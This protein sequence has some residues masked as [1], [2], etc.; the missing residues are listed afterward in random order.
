MKISIWLLLLLLLIQATV[1]AVLHWPGGGDS[2]LAATGALLPFDPARID[3]V[4]IGDEYDNEVVLLQVDKAHWALPEMDDLPANANA[5]RQLVTALDSS[6]HQVPIATT[7]AA[8]QRFQVASYR[9]QRQIRLVGNGEILAT[10]YLGTAPGFRQV[11]ARNEERDAIYNIA[12]NNHDAPALASAWLDP[13]L[14]RISQPSRV[15]NDVFDIRLDAG[16]RWLNLAGTTPNAA[17]LEKLLDA[18]AE[19]EVAG[20]ADED[21]QRSLSEVAEPSLS[22]RIDSSDDTVLLEF[23]AVDDGYYVHDSRYSL[24]FKLPAQNYSRFRQLR[25]ERLAEA[26]PAD[27][28]SAALREPR[29]I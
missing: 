18:L 26:D 28:N 8:R 20:L 23:F 1:I 3:E 16:D 9:Y 12:Y 29:P 25:L 5:V 6:R 14:L 21:M 19:L 24:F 11:H 4:H 13:K 17:V 22:L 2:S 10:I 27:P 7:I 15:A